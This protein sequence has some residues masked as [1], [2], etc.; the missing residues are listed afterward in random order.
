MRPSHSQLLE[1]E[2]KKVKIV[3]T[4]SGSNQLRKML[5]NNIPKIMS[6]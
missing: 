4:L 1:K 6:P 5:Q 3:A 2:K